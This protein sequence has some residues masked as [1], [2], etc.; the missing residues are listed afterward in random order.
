MANRPVTTATEARAG[1]KEGVVRY[2]LL[3]SLVLVVVL[4]A[5]AYLIFW[6]QEIAARYR[7]FV[8]LTCALVEAL[9]VDFELGIP[10]GRFGVADDARVENG[11]TSSAL[12][13]HASSDLTEMRSRKTMT[14][15]W[16]TTRRGRFSPKP[17]LRHSMLPLRTCSASVFGSMGSSSA[18]RDMGM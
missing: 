16:V 2:V 11:T 3:T 7:R 12:A 4:F 6:S 10:V 17:F 14:S 18:S 9:A 15:G 13:R 1:S 5:V 8:P